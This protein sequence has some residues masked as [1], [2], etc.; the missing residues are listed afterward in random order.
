MISAP[1]IGISCY[2]QQ[3]RWGAWDLR[4]SLLPDR[5]VASVAAAG[6]IPVL[7]P[8]VPL[9]EEAVPRLDAIILAGGGD[10]DPARYGAERDPHCGPSS[11]ERDGAELALAAAG[12]ATGVPVLGICRGLQVLNVALGGTLHQHLPDVVGH[13]GHSPVPD[14]YGAHEVSVAPGS[15][16]AAILNRTDLTDHLPVVVPTHHHQAI[17][18]LGDGLAAT[19]WATDG[20]IEAAELDPA[21]HPFVVAVQWHP[22]AGEDLS[23]FRALVAAAA[24][25][26]ETVPA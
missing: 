24:R 1:L 26:S 18:V 25:R 4:A 8:P 17:D 16:L 7:L 9:V 10:I 22:E 11:D 23:L 21:R 2:R 20:T 5:Y 14:G 12:L 13:D 15:R 19:A 6:G 3:A